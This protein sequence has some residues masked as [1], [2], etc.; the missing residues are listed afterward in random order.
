VGKDKRKLYRTAD[1]I[2]P[3]WLKNKEVFHFTFSR[4]EPFHHLR[5]IS[6]F[7]HEVD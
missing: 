2:A 1:R 5:V 4:M 3:G 7:R 6:G